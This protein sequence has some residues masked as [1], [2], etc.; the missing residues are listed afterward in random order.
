M[1]TGLIQDI[2]RLRRV[3]GNAL[4]L[5][6][7]HGWNDLVHGES[8]AVNGA[9]LT[10]ERHDG[11][12]LTFHTLAETLERTNLGA[13]GAGGLVNL[14]RALKVGDPI[15][16]HLVSGHVDASG[17]VRA[18]RPLPG[19][20]LELEVEAP[21][22][23]LPFLAA[24]GSVAVD[25]ISLTVVKVTGDSF[26]VDLI[27]VTRQETA[28]GERQTGDRVNLE[29]DMLAKYVA[30][31]LELRAAAGGSAQS[32]ITMKTLFDAGFGR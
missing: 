29:S 6:A 20:D 13:L 24:K 14:E 30:R 27:P 17:V 23:L 9:C 22:S 10:L 1:F 16:G 26:T 7:L 5:E 15:G 8:I 3:G 25:G 31:Q 4:E 11:R 12:H 19:G 21:A 32:P 28:L 18:W 2:G